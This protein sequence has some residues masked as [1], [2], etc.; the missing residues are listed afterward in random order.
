M[1]RQCTKLTSMTWAVRASLLKKKSVW[2]L[3][4]AG[5][6]MGC[7]MQEGDVPDT[8]CPIGFQVTAAAVESRSAYETTS[9]N[10]KDRSLE[11]YAFAE[12][13]RPFMGRPGGED[14]S[15]LSEGVEICHDGIGWNYA[16]PA[17]KAYWPT[18]SLDF[19]AFHPKLKATPGY[20]LQVTS[21]TKQTLRYAL[22]Q[23]PERQI[24]VLYAIHRH[25]TR[26]MHQGKAPLHF[27]H[28]LTQASF[29][30]RTELPSL[31]ID[32]E[33]LKIHNLAFYGALTLPSGAETISQSDWAPGDKVTL[34]YSP[35]RLPAAIEHISSQPVGVSQ[36][37][38]LPQVLTAWN[39]AQQSIREADAARHSYLSVLCRIRQHGVYL[40]GNAQHYERMFIPF[41][42]SW[43]PGKRY[44][45]T[46]TFGG[47]YDETG[48]KVMA[49]LGFDVQEAVWDSQSSDVPVVPL[50]RGLQ[51]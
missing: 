33:D 15:S 31:E 27:H 36:Q 42:A 45:Y 14:A 28:A 40:W 5:L 43:E 44:V 35:K 21:P 23:I 30:A 11:V 49:P 10:L 48:Q 26:E 51:E 3:L 39:P 7:S 29:L 34:D 1:E 4:A 37:L 8:S 38:Y 47:G 32:I 16:D 13:G 46:L 12:D 50:N 17:D 24:D 20:S 22:S 9:E 6:L 25:V 19:I 18:G 2:A 41:A